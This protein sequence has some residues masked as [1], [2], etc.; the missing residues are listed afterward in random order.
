MRENWIT[1]RTRATRTNVS[2]VT[3]KAFSKRI[4]TCTYR[5]YV[6]RYQHP[7]SSSSTRSRLPPAP[8]P[9][10]RHLRCF[11]SPDGLIHNL[12]TTAARSPPLASSSLPA[13]HRR[14]SQVCTCVDEPNLTVFPRGGSSLP[15]QVR[16]L[17]VK[18]STVK[19]RARVVSR[20]E[21]R[22]HFQRLKLEFWQIVQLAT[23]VPPNIDYE[24]I[25]HYL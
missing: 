17:T 10:P 25:C 13:A 16:N 5:R 14:V 4:H 12:C 9:V 24:F 8:V 20:R 2:N 23:Q 3:S 19:R 22:P 7:L 6:S 21:I 15:R 18:R 11:P 1:P